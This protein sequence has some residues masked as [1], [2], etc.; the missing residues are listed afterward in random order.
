MTAIS[1]TFRRLS[2]AREGAYIPYICCGDCGKD[3]TLE[4]M[5]RF[6]R[7]GADIIELG[8]P[9]SDPLADGPTIQAAM[10]RSLESGFRVADIFD[11]IQ[12]ARANGVRAPIVVMTYYNPIV[13]LG[14]DEFCSRL[15]KAGGNAI[16]PVDLP[17]EESGDL[18]HAAEQSGLDLIRLIAPSTDEERASTILGATTG[19]AYAVSVSGVTGER[20]TLPESALSLL[21]R[22]RKQSDVP[23]AL[24][25]GVSTPEHAHAAML[26]GASGVVEGSALINA[27]MSAE[28]DKSE[29]LR[30]AEAHARG[31]KGATTSEAR[32]SKRQE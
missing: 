18:D 31:I 27:Y 10:M 25:F 28:P 12:D 11:T 21:R 16:L 20:N 22:L 17:I 7:V 29:G 15:A 23:I 14:A 5:T 26:A 24:G 3:F 30:L 9:F 4:L 13:R 6:E 32:D 2:E 8:L 1:D 19:F